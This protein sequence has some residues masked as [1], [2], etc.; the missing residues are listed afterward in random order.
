M[1]EDANFSTLKHMM[2]SP[3][4]DCEQLRSYEVRPVEAMG[5]TTSL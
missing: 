3:G 1:G 2:R 5:P 4:G